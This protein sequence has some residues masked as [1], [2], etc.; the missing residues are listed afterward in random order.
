ME[1]GEFSVSIPGSRISKRDRAFE[2]GQQGGHDQVSRGRGALSFFLTS[3]KLGK[4]KEK[5]R[6]K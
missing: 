2:A 5:K 6:N 4:E 3:D 1:T